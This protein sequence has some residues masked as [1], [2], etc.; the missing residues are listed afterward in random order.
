MRNVYSALSLIFIV[1]GA[2]L[3]GSILNDQVIAKLLS[4]GYLGPL[5]FIF[6]IFYSAVAFIFAFISKEM[7]YRAILLILSTTLLIISLIFT[8]VGILGFRNP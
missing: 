6:L 8:F 4:F 3:L 5:T 2:L 7:K 1:I